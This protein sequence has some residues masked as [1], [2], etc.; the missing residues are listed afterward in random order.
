MRK[1]VLYFC[2]LGA[3]WAQVPEIKTYGGEGRFSGVL[4]RYLPV[5]QPQVNYANSTR[6]DSLMRGEHLF[7]FA[8]CD[9]TGT[10]E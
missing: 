1:L 7:V 9:R 10:G 5:A 2:L 4:K 8:R 3:A 6:L